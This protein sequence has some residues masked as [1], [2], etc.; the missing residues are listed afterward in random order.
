MTAL[1]DAVRQGKV[2]YIGVSNFR[3][4]Q[5]E[6]AMPLQRPVGWNSSSLTLRWRGVDSNFQFRAK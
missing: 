4:E 6:E 1:D 2:R 3:P 5:I